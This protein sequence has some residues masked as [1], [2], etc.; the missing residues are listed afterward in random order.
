MGAGVSVYNTSRRLRK[1]KNMDEREKLKIKIL[2]QALIHV[3]F[4][5]WSQ[6]LLEQAA[7]ESDVDPSYAWRLFPKG[8]LEAVSFWSH[9]LDQEMLASLPAAETLRV[10]DRI[11]LAVRTRLTLLSTNRQAALKTARYLSRPPH[12]AEASRLVYQT[13]NQMWYYAG[14]TSTDYNFYTKRGLL[15]WVYSSTFVY[16]TQD[17]SEGFEKTWT[18]LDRRIEEVLKI[19]KLFQFPWKRRP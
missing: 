4:E 12:L 13:V 15:A 1:G 6:E 7:R 9:L 3:P 10:R 14:D 11:A 16:W 17:T 18:F 2:N 19:P 5:G 8:P